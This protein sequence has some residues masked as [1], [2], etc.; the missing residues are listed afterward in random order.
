MTEGDASLE[1]YLYDPKWY[2]R[3]PWN[4]AMPPLSMQV[5]EG[6]LYSPEFYSSEG[7]MPELPDA[8]LLTPEAPDAE[9]PELEPGT[10][11]APAAE[12]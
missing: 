9:L 5:F 1:K 6:A 11:P 10:P 3:E 2:L 7:L 8:E 12:P 4:P